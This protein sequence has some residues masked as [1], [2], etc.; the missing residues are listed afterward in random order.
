M[1]Y[2]KSLNEI[3]AIQTSCVACG[4]EKIPV[5]FST[6]Y[7]D[8]DSIIE[9]AEHIKNFISNDSVFG[10]IGGEEFAIICSCENTSK[11][12]S[13][14]DLLREEIEALQISTLDGNFIKF[15][16]N[17]GVSK[18]SDEF[19]NIDQL[20]KKADEALCKAKN[21][22]RNKTVIKGS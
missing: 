11:L 4:N 22:V 16:I 12:Q 1:I 5:I 15:T 8:E 20:L 18:M 3:N 6:A 13:K 19:K 17:A 21:T 7:R 9:A 10:R 2:K 14:L